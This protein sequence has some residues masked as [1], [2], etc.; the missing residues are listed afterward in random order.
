MPA[1][2]NMIKNHSTTALRQTA[3][4]QESAPVLITSPPP[5]ENVKGKKSKTLGRVQSV[6]DE[7]VPPLPSC[8]LSIDDRAPG[9]IKIFG[10]SVVHGAQYK[11]VLASTRS[12]A[13]E[14][15]KQALERYG[16]STFNHQD[17]VLCDTIG[18]LKPVPDDPHRWVVVCQRALKDSDKPLEFQEFWKPLDGYYRRYQLHKKSEF[19]DDNI[20]DDTSGINDNARKIMMSKVH[21]GAIPV[22]SSWSG[23]EHSQETVRQDPDGKSLQPPV[24]DTSSYKEKILTLQSLSMYPYLLTIRGYQVHHDLVLYPLRAKSL[25][26]GRHNSNSSSADIVCFAPDIFDHHCRLNPRTYL[27]KGINQQLKYTFYIELEVFPGAHVT[28]NGRRVVGK[29]ELHSGDLLSLGKHYLFLYKDPTNGFDIPSK[30]S[31]LSSKRD[32]VG[33]RSSLPVEYRTHRER[34]TV[35]TSTSE[36]LN[37]SSDNHTSFD[38]SDDAVT[39]TTA[40]KG[41]TLNLS[42]GKDREE[43]VLTAISGLKCLN[44]RDHPL[45]SAMLFILCHDCAVR[46]FTRHHT[47]NM[48]RRMLACIQN[49]VSSVARSLSQQKFDCIKLTLKNSSNH[50]ESA[51][52]KHLMYWMSNSISLYCHM[53]SIDTEN[54]GSSPEPEDETNNSL[55]EFLEGLEEIVSFCFQQTV[56]CITKVLYPLTNKYLDSNPFSE[57][58]SVETDGVEKTI[59]ILHSALDL[60]HSVLLH[61]DVRN[62]MM[63]YLLFFIGTSL[64]NRLMKKGL[65][66]EY[67]NWTFG[68]RLQANIGR[69][70]DWLT[71]K[72]L[73]TDFQKVCGK[74]IAVANLLATSKQQLL[75]M[76]RESIS[77]EFSQLNSTQIS[78]ILRGY[79]IGQGRPAPDHWFSADSSDDA[80]D[81]NIS[82]ASYPVFLLPTTGPDAASMTYND[83]FYETLDRL[84]AAFGSE[85]GDGDSGFSVSNTPRLTESMI[86]TAE[87]NGNM[88]YHT[89][90]PRVTVKQHPRLLLDNHNSSSI[91]NSPR[92]GHVY[93]P[94][95]PDNLSSAS[96]Y[97]DCDNDTTDDDTTITWREK[98]N[99]LINQSEIFS[100]VIE[101][102][103]YLEPRRRSQISLNESFIDAPPSEIDFHSCRST[104]DE[105]NESTYSDNLTNGRSDTSH[106]EVV[107]NNI[108]EISRDDRKI[109]MKSE[110]MGE[111]FTVSMQKGCGPLGLGLIDGLYT[112][113]KS[114]GIYIRNILPDS[115]AEKCGLLAVGDRIMAV[116][117]TSVVGASYQLAMDY[118]VSTGRELHMVVARSPLDVIQHIKASIS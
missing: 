47:K 90:S 110:K 67:Y 78:K 82:L 13:I 96:D 21:V 118:I 95:P 52:L 36:E 88:F 100:D 61:D 11:S 41:Q 74:L 5:V 40:P 48:Y 51:N 16:L 4:R 116:N 6:K 14:L 10:D 72:N 92:A 38:V 28:V 112:P 63:T 103:I 1:T 85:E 31:W 113:L 54:R 34:V 68:V 8:E 32:T 107:T 117:E 56:Y 22:S 59:F 27:D 79:Q 50:Q 7:R 83:D 29:A 86:N 57:T 23:S 66:Q 46:K 45:T 69:L 19:L 53:V 20:A 114:A 9:V 3:S 44:R 87:S 73:A 77:S 17:Y 25:I 12:T 76:E 64:F 24:F 26:L 2:S 105:Q 43:E 75:K 84:N 106:D 65:E 101:E 111:I 80:E 108:R 60:A 94:S 39:W 15:I 35:S 70:E 89:E 109:L 102:N 98:P 58:I 55:K 99:N 37:T 71:E 33:K 93:P 42:Y 81:L 62:Q 49:S 97:W 104:S 18:K 30:L 91:P 115:E